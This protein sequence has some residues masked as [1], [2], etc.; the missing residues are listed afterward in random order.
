ME[1]E[2]KFLRTFSLIDTRVKA[3]NTERGSI[4]ALLTS[5]LTGLES[6]NSKKFKIQKYKNYPGQKIYSYGLGLSFQK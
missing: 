4:T 6:K 5:C 3:G 1:L 2:T